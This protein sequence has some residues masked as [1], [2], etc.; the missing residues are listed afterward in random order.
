MCPFEREDLRVY[1]RQIRNAL[2]NIQEIIISVQILQ[3]LSHIDDVKKMI[4]HIL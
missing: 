3:N 1:G 2:V 4:I